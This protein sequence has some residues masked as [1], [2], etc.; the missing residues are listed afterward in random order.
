MSE[1]ATVNFQPITG[2]EVGPAVWHPGWLP[3][4]APFPELADARTE[5]DRLSAAWRDAGARRSALEAQ[6]EAEAEQRSGSL[7][8]AYLRGEEPQADEAD[9]TLAGELASAKQHSQAALDALMAQINNTIL[10]VVEH[11]REWLEEIAASES[12][13]EAEI[14]A[15]E[16]RLRELRASQGTRSNIEYWISRTAEAASFT[17]QHFPYAELPSTSGD[18]DRDMLAAMHRS[19]AGDQ[20][21]I[22]NAQADAMQARSDARGEAEPVPAAQV[23]EMGDEDLVDWLMS[24]GAF[25]K[26]P[27]PDSSAVIAA[28]EGDP[29]LAARLLEAERRANPE[30]PRAD[31][32]A[33]LLEIT[34]RKAGA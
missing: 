14:A 6:I 17:I 3:D 4:A 7:R 23:G 15:T 16:A 34:H 30:A 31:V 18:A 32:L 8:D 29:V 13:I 27:K 12:G 20:K 22:S 33:A 24:T 28:A 11:Q 1:A 10:L 21:L 2:S 25:D 19:Y 26:E 5:Y 9:A